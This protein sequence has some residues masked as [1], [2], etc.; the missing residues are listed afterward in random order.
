LI[1]AQRSGHIVNISAAAAI[2]NY[3]GFSV[4]GAAKRAVEGLSEALVAELRP[5]GGRVTIVQPGPL[6]TGF[7]GRSLERAGTHIP[8]Y[9]STS[10][11]FARALEALNGR[12]SGDPAR[13]AA[14]IAAIVDSD[15]PPLRLVL[16][17]Y[18]REKAR[19]SAEDT[20]R[21]LAVWE[22]EGLSIDNQPNS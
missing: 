3:A 18:A 16:G 1:R 22:V 8:D 21:E 6:R 2:M 13:A 20:T 4:Y 5:F 17:K 12:Q 14:A 10:G 15:S 11:K 9:D 19:R 7:A